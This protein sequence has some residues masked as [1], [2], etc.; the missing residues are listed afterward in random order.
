MSGFGNIF[1]VKIGG[2][3]GSIAEKTKHELQKISVKD[4]ND[5]AKRVEG[6]IRDVPSLKSIFENAQGELDKM[7]ISFD[8]YAEISIDSWQQAMGTYIHMINL[9]DPIVPPDQLFAKILSG[10]YKKLALNSPAG[11]GAGPCGVLVSTG[12]ILIGE[13]IKANGD[14]YKDTAEKLIVA[15]P[16]LGNSACAYL[17]G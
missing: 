8:R 10:Q 17:G 4:V 5:L 2:T 6:N 11:T 3:L 14:K 9:G 13:I 7:K 15:A 1:D 12:I 16:V